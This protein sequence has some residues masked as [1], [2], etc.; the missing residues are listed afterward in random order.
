MTENF[1]IR[2]LKSFFPL[3][4]DYQINIYSEM[5]PLYQHWNEKINIISKKDISQLFT[6]HILHSLSIANIIK[7]KPWNTILDV[8]TGGGFPGIPLAV[9]F[10]ECKFTLIDSVGKKIT[11]VEEIANTLNLKNVKAFK[12][13]SNEIKGQY[14]YI[15]GRAVSSFPKFYNEVK[16]LTPRNGKLIYLKGGDF[17]D[18]IKGFKNIRIHQISKYFEDEFFE[19]KKIIHFIKN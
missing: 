9:M 2:R 10:P 16:H 5:I 1:N 3:L 18:E 8:G 14:D 7:F 6:H 13:R 17:E 4:T 19:T 11:V 15:T 12:A